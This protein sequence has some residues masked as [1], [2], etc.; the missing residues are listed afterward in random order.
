MHS[1]LKNDSQRMI[2][3]AWI[4]ALH[5]LATAGF[6]VAGDEVPLKKVPLGQ[7]LT[8]TSPVDDAVFNRISTTALKLQQQ[9][10]QEERPAVLVLQI[11]PGTSQ[12]HSV[13]SATLPP[14]MS[15]MTVC[16]R[17][18]SPVLA[19]GAAAG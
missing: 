9:A 18:I 19:A 8:V 15:K 2:A 11:D 13:G 16:S 7:F 17:G 3:L 14:S 1:T 6:V 4:A 12:F 5:L 10:S